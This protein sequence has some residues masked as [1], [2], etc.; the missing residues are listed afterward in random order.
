MEKLENDSLSLSLTHTPIS[1]VGSPCPGG[2]QARDIGKN[3]G[4]SHR[5]PWM[6]RCWVRMF[7]GHY[8][9]CLYHANID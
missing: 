4:V 5:E 9:N 3:V 1:T 6:L 2:G 8:K 7:W